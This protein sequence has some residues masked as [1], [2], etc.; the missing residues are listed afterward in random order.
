MAED[1][2]DT[3]VGR[4]GPRPPSSPPPLATP[5]PESPARPTE[6]T[7]HARPRHEP[8]LKDWTFPEGWQSERPDAVKLRLEVCGAVLDKRMKKLMN[9]AEMCGMAEEVK[10]S[11]EFWRGLKGRAT[12][13]GIKAGVIAG[14]IVINLLL[15]GS[16]AVVGLITTS[17]LAGFANAFF[18]EHAA[19]G[20][21]KESTEEGRMLIAVVSICLAAVGIGYTNYEALSGDLLQRGSDFLWGL[22]PWGGK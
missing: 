13:W 3:V 16:A 7:Q 10:K 22:W 1:I 11:V 5:T 14:A 6:T 4:Q 12:E 17:T 19:K 20:R 21:L 18:H 2:V 9:D 15:P 8:T